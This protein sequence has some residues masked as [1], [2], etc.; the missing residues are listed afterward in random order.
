MAE[1]WGV[2]DLKI[3]GAR[4]R[5]GEEARGEEA[6]GEG[7]RG[8]GARG[9]GASLIV[10]GRRGVVPVETHGRASQTVQMRLHP[11]RMR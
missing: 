8:E 6:R 10:I 9:E 1:V 3:G 4:G 2:E 11:F 7:A 5:G